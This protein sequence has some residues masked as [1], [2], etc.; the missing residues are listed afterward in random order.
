MI[1]CSEWIDLSLSATI[2]C[3]STSRL[4]VIGGGGTGAL[5]AALRSSMIE[6]VVPIASGMMVLIL[7]VKTR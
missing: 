6:E 1:P 2:G 5:S 7:R 3:V 4:E